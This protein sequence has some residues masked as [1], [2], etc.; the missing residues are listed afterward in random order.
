ML[1]QLTM[2]AQPIFRL[3]P[4]DS[5]A[6]IL[7][8]VSGGK[9]SLAMVLS[10]LE[11]GADPRKMWAWHQAIDGR[12][13]WKRPFFDWPVTEE[14]TTALMKH[15]NIPLDFQWRD[16][17]FHGELYREDA[18]SH[19]VHY[20]DEGKLL[21]LPTTERGSISTRKRWPAK[22]ANLQTRRC[23][24]TLK[25]DV[26]RR[27]INAIK[28]S[29]P[30]GSSILFVSGERREESPAR[31]KLQNAE[32]HMCSSRDYRV[33]HFRPVLEW[34]E[35]DVWRIIEKHRIQPHPAYYLGFPRLSCRSCIFYSPNHWATL[36]AIQPHVIEMIHEIER[37]LNFT[38]AH[39]LNIHE[40]VSQ[41]KSLFADEA[42]SYLPMTLQE[43]WTGSIQMD[44]WMLPN[45][46]FG[47]EGGSI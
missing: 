17:G 33:D 28:Y 13:Q 44:E 7:C 11:Q 10:L 46:A 9:D 4:L 3:Q 34:K 14:Y 22:T 29:L 32:P 26:A 38:L 19:G 15:L 31:A 1:A 47:K 42:L 18:R 40:V 16:Y 30:R 23:S 2:F 12:G 36:Q 43:Q 8:Q 35:D 21:Y 45:G 20:T 39:K 5:Y 37:E 27:V 25:I 6:L 41:G 24:S